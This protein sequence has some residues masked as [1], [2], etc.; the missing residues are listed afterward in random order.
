MIIL[1]R[2]CIKIETLHGYTIA[3]LQEEARITT[4]EYTRSLL[5]TV[6]MRYNGA[7]TTLITQTLGK[8]RPTIA[9]Y[10]KKWNLSPA[11]LI[12]KRGNNVPSE[13]SVDIIEEIKDIILN[14]EP[15]EYGFQ[16]GSWTSAALAKYVEEHYGKSRSSSLFR[17]ILSSIG[18]SYK[19]GAYVPSKGDPVLQE[20]F[21]KNVKITGYN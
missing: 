5:L 2:A 6:I 14:H 9:E 11:N 12:D 17:R 1:A 10:I 4:S 21:K 15:S 8:S 19:R 7:S 18:F 3:D 16:Q 20:E 13:I